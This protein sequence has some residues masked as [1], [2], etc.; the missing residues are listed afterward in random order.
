MFGVGVGSGAIDVVEE[1]GVAIIA[2]IEEV[3][4]ATIVVE[5]GAGV[6]VGGWG[7]LYILFACSAS[8]L[9]MLTLCPIMAPCSLGT[10]VIPPPSPN[11]L[12]L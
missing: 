5:D 8:C 1:V 9:L 12:L 3:G 11:D 10:M 2:D 7:Q 4:S 6:E